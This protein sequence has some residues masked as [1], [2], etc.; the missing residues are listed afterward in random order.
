MPS[1]YQKVDATQFFE[2]ITIIKTPEELGNLEKG[3]K[4][5][6]FSLK[7]L[8]DEVEEIIDNDD[9]VLMNEL[10]SKVKNSL[11]NENNKDMKVFINSNPSIDIANLDY[12]LPIQIQSGGNFTYDLSVDSPSQ[13]LTDDTIWLSMCCE[14]AEVCASAA[15]TLIINPTQQEKQDYLLLRKAFSCLFSSIKLGK[16]IS[17]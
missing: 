5:L 3:A 16:K 17:D 2:K 15:R 14:Y 13:N 9:D 6:D 1:D 8:I 11:E 10:S 12:N 4:F 7:K